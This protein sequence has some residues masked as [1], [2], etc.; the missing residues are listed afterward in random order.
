M[1][2][3][4]CNATDHEPGARFCHK[5]GHPLSPNREIGIHM[6]AK[7]GFKL[8]EVGGEQIIAAEGKDNIDF[9]KIISMNESSAYLWE[10]VQ[11]LESFT[12]ED[13]AKLLLAQYE[14]DEQTALIDARTLASQWLKAGI[15]SE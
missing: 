12:V 14:I 4:N 7:P 13:L 11:Q 15:V 6:K 8:R 5:C 10:E 2:C 9:S 1:K 3:P